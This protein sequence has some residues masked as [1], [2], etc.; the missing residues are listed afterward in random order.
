M[1]RQAPTKKSLHE[2]AER[3]LGVGAKV[4]VG[5][6]WAGP[7]RFAQARATKASPAGFINVEITVP[8]T[9]GDGL[10]RRTREALKDALD[11][12]GKDD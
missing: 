7:Q 11:R 5:D 10:K 12:L 3:V 8:R 9:A 2:L 4:S 6:V 1:P